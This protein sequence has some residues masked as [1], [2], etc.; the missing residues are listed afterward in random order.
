MAI[1][2]RRRLQPRTII[3][4]VESAIA[5][6]VEDGEDDLVLPEHLVHALI[7]VAKRAP[8]N[9]GRTFTSKS[10]RDDEAEVLAQANARRKALVKTGTSKGQATEQAAEEA[11]A[12][13]LPTRV[14]SIDTIK[15]RM[16]RKA[17]R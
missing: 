13:L 15:D 12:K 4:M 3:R 1:T 8:N 14:L 7:K 16:G 6:Q 10:A 17:R 5:K 2:W 11:Q 9:R